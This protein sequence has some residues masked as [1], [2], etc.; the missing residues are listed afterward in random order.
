MLWQDIYLSKTIAPRELTTALAGVFGL[1]SA[2]VRVAETEFT[3]KA[4]ATLKVLCEATRY[5]G[6]FPLRLE[7]YLYDPALQRDATAV[8]TQLCRA[9]RCQALISDGSGNPYARLLV[10]ADGEPRTVLLDVQ[11][12]DAQNVLALKD[13]SELWPFTRRQLASAMD[14]LLEAAV[15][16]MAATAAQSAAITLLYD[17]LHEALEQARPDPKP[18]LEAAS[19]ARVA[20]PKQ[21]LE[22]PYLARLL[23]LAEGIAN[24]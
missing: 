18:L 9:L 5:G 3:D 1:K 16:P 24:S 19:A 11:A 2:A 10:K 21:E 22:Q 4:P 13:A 12:L 15:P 20:W 23:E 6:D 14:Y 17:A 8:T 7:L